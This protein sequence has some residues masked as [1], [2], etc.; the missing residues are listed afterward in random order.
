M[1]PSIST[2]LYEID[3]FVTWLYEKYLIFLEGF[4][5]FTSTIIIWNIGERF[6]HQYQLKDEGMKKYKLFKAEFSIMSRGLFS[7]FKE[8]QNKSRDEIEKSVSYIFFQLFFK[9]YADIWKVF[10]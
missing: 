10:F 3:S 6:F 8:L 4:K 5:L 9:P 7:K 1:G 2:G